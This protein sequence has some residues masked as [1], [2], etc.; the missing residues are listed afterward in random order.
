[1]SEISES[2]RI[3]DQLKRA[4]EGDAWH[5]PAL[6]EIL[7]D[8]DAAKAARRPIA[9]AHT[10]WELT[11]HVAGW[12]GVVVRRL[13]GK[14]C[15]LE[16]E[17]NFPIIVDTGQSAWH[18]AVETLKENHAELTSEVSAMTDSRLAERVPGK[19]Y[20]IYFMLHGAIQHALYHAGQM[21]ILKKA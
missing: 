13:R 18:K 20:D 19:D 4:F 2:T 17:D 3:T 6:L 7:S 14:A 21:A 9:D 10:I 15:T 1:M 8:V 11:L 5:G 12:D 16:G